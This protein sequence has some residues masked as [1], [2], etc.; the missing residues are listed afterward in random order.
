MP[1]FA[2]GTTRDIRELIF[3]SHID[4]GTE[5]TMTVESNPLTGCQ[6]TGGREELAAVS[7]DDKKK[8]THDYLWGE[9]C[10]VC[11]SE[12]GEMCRPGCKWEPCPGCGYPWRDGGCQCSFDD[13]ET[14]DKDDGQD[15]PD[16]Y[17]YS[18]PPCGDWGDQGWEDRDR[19]W[20]QVGEC[21]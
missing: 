6:H 1:F 2:T 12:A 3:G 18:T 7:N 15:D 4:K 8:T 5:M 10:T 16:R 19:E 20:E 9:L 14:E 11:G 21:D 17:A 13:E